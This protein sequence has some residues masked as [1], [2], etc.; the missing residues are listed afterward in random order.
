MLSLIKCG[1]MDYKMNNF[2]ITTMLTKYLFIVLCA[3]F[4]LTHTHSQSCLSPCQSCQFGSGNKCSTCISGFI[5]SGDYCAPLNC[6]ILYCQ[7]C[8]DYSS[9]ICT[10][11]QNNFVLINNTC[12]CQTNYAP[13]VPGSP[14]TSCI[15]PAPGNTNSN[16]VCISCAI[17]GCL[18]CRNATVC[19]ACASG[20]GLNSLGGC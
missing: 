18:T 10:V 4:L 13:K 14:N 8:A 6:S 3:A 16:P 17:P 12:I 15:C 9:L 11:C 19:Q 20:Y 5:I 7:A 1:M 2:I